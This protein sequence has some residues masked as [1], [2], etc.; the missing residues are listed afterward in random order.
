MSAHPYRSASDRQLT[1]GDA[2][3]ENPF[4]Y[5]LNDLGERTALEIYLPRSETDFVS[6]DLDQF[7]LAIQRELHEVTAVSTTYRSS[8]AIASMLTR[9]CARLSA[10]Y[11]RSGVVYLHAMEPAVRPRRP[12]R[13]EGD[14]G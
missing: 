13:R 12:A 8:S 10:Y 9:P 11:S 4:N 7:C 3:S 2:I 6:L 5:D 1:H 14:A